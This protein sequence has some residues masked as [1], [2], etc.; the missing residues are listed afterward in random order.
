MGSM[1]AL[2]V[3]AGILAIVEFSAGLISTS[4]RSRGASSWL[5]DKDEHFILEGLGRLRRELSTALVSVQPHPV[6]DGASNSS[7][8][9]R[10]LRELAASCLDDCRVLLE[11]VTSIL[12][13]FPGAPRSEP[14]AE[15]ICR[16]ISARDGR[17]RE[18]KSN[19]LSRD[20]TLHV[21]SIVRCAT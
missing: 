17:P 19:G 13:D 21:R 1:L 11:D 20:V 7:S 16:L 8:D 18:E 15:E 4:A 2:D 3:A 12:K 14:W 10:A 6:S 5:D 9:A